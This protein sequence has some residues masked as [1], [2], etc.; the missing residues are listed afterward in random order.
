MGRRRWVA[1]G[2]S[3]LIAICPLGHFPEKPLR[4]ILIMLQRHEPKGLPLNVPTRDQF[5]LIFI[6]MDTG[7]TL[8]LRF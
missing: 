4:F 2:F 3:R 5:S 1:A 6:G 7:T 8:P